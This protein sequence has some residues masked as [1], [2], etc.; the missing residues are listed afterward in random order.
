[1]EAI[2][3]KPD[4]P[5]IYIS[6]AR[7][8]IFAGKYDDALVN[9]ENSL[10]LNPN[11]SM[12]HAVRGWALSS[13]GS[14]VVVGGPGPSFAMYDATPQGAQSKK[15]V[16]TAGLAVDRVPAEEWNQIFN[17]VWRIDGKRNLAHKK[18][19]FLA[20]RALGRQRRPLDSATK[21]RTLGQGSS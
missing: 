3:I 17:E 16:S 18:T 15:P 2:R 1:M 6:L 4:D 5:S 19:R 9:A 20:A 7:V 21:A 8:Q 10:L 12:A 11:N 13:D 14:K